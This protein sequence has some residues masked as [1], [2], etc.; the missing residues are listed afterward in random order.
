MICGRINDSYIKF[1]FV[2][3]SIVV[4][5]CSAAVLMCSHWLQVQMADADRGCKVD[6]GKLQQWRCCDWFSC[7]CCCC[8]IVFPAGSC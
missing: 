3:V 5:L 4:G 8:V 7:K 6:T 2:L 1:V